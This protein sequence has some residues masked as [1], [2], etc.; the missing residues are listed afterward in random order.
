M[1]TLCENG[2]LSLFYTA[3][4]YNSYREGRLSVRME[5]S[6]FP[7]QL[8]YTTH[9]EKADSLSEWRPLSL[10]YTDAIY[11][12]YREGRL[13][14]RMEASLFSVQMLYLIKIDKADS[15]S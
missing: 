12:S 5:A 6:L 9:I 4:I 8:L 15:L 14:V 3:A 1:Q 11:N 2:G 7:I 10:F 13:S